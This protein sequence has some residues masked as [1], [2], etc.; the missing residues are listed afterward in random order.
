[1]ASSN[2]CGLS[3]SKGSGEVLDEI[4]CDWKVNKRNVRIQLFLCLFRLAHRARRPLD[5]RPRLVALPVGI[6]YKLVSEWLLGIEIPWRTEIGP[7]L[8]LYHGYGTVINDGCKL[9][10]NVILRHGVTLGHLF[11][12]GPCPT[13]EDSVEFGA[14]AQVLG[15]VRVGRGARV[16]AG[17]VVTHDVPPSVTVVGIP[18]RPAMQSLRT[19]P[20]S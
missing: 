19:E 16:G 12:G 15:G 20:E 14:G 8:R 1:M 9:G 10:C 11:E 3:E 6:L 18:A 4:L 7:G 17:A 2:G 13:I 5:R